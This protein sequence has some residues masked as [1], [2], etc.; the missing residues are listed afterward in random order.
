MRFIPVWVENPHV[1]AFA[2]IIFN[3][4]CRS[5]S[6]Q[7]HRL[8]RSINGSGELVASMKTGTVDERIQGPGRALLGT[9]LVLGHAFKHMYNAGFFIVLPELQ[10]HF[11][12]SNTAIGTLSTIRNTG[13]GLVNL[14]AGYM[15]DRF[16]DRWP[17]VLSLALATMGIF[18]LLM[19]TFESYWLL[20]I[21]ATLGGMSISFWHPSAIT[22]LSQKFAH[23]RGFA[24]AMHGTGGSIGEALGP[25]M[26]GA[27]LG[28]VVWQ[29]ILQFG[30]IPAV[31][32]AV[33]VAVTLRGLRGDSANPVAFSEYV[34]SIYRLIRQ[35]GMFTV[36]GVTAGATSAHAIVLTFLPIY[37]SVDLE[38]SAFEMSAFISASQVMGI[39]S[40]PLMGYLSD[41]YTRKTVLLPTLILLSFGILAVP[42]VGT[43]IPLIIAILIMGAAAFPLVAILLA[44]AMDVTEEGIPGTTVSLVFSAAILFSAVTPA[45]AGGLAD[46]YGVKAAFFMASGITFGAAIFTALRSMS[47]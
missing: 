17:L 39:M 22:A 12:L 24:I 43:G 3:V 4:Q 42:L 18:H 27:L 47:R 9:V 44:A 31:V 10:L 7:F 6:S 19:G 36:L 32:V 41:R 34:S 21:M 11:R 20:V 28:I 25:I 5:V 1:Y 40:Q 46:T 8:E 2:K 26:V 14:P 30:V 23:R 13:A 37:L 35:R 45:I 33:V 16:T 29:S 15:A 38:Y